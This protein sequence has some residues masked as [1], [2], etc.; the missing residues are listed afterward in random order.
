MSVRAVR[1]AVRG[2]AITAESVEQN[3]Y[4]AVAQ[5]TNAVTKPGALTT[6]WWS[7]IIAGAVSSVLAAVGVPGSSAAQVAG[8]VAPVVLALV[9]AFVRTQHKGTLADALQAVFPQARAAAQ[10]SAAAP[11][12]NGQ[13]A[14]PASAVAAPPQ[15]LT[16]GAG[17]VAPA[18]PAEAPKP[19]EAVPTGP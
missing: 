13:Q 7:V 16:L 12:Q 18:A 8:I 1:D 11:G 5:I 4:E 17:A 19:A 2:T 15:A 6:E 14:A 10:A 9:Y 3:P